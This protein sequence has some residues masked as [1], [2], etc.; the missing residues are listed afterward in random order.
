MYAP[1]YRY[2]K[3]TPSFHTERGRGLS[4][5]RSKLRHAG[6]KGSASS[7]LGRRN[8][9]TGSLP[10]ALAQASTGPF[11]AF[12]Q[13]LRRSPRQSRKDRDS[14]AAV[15]G[16]SVDITDASIHTAVGNHRRR[17]FNRRS[18]SAPATP[19]HGDED[20]HDDVYS[21]APYKLLTAQLA[22]RQDSQPVSS[23]S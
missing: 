13:R 3:S 12:A 4:Q 7:G 20:D 5:S 6:G 2:Q 14:F 18:I 21:R 1:K 23:C 15:A 16:E 17:Q 22:A 8:S 19:M 10:L 9:S 11:S